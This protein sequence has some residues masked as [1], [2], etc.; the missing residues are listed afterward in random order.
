M[1]PVSHLSLKVDVLVLYTYEAWHSNPFLGSE[2][3]LIDFIKLAWPDSNEAMKNTKLELT[4]NLVTL[5][6]VSAG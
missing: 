2:Q 3:E 1:H 6:R 5:Q 4:L